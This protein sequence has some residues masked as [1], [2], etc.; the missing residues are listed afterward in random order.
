MCFYYSSHITRI[1]FK[2]YHIWFCLVPLCLSTII[3]LPIVHLATILYSYVTI[4]TL[5]LENWKKETVKLTEVWL[6]F[7]FLLFHWN[8]SGWVWRVHLYLHSGL[9]RIWNETIKTNPMLIWDCPVH[10][11]RVPGSEVLWSQWR[12][13]FVDTGLKFTWL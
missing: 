6:V 12:H 9:H 13:W 8:G 5:K 10:K 2:A 3:S 11:L 7:R 4:N 1:T